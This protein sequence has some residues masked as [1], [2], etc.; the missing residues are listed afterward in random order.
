MVGM[1]ETVPVNVRAWAEAAQCRALPVG[2][3][4]ATG[5]SRAA[6]QRARRQ[7]SCR[8]AADYM[9]PIQSLKAS[10]G[11]EP[12]VHVAMMPP[13]PAAPRAVIDTNAVLDW[14]VFAEPAALTL[15]D[16][17]ARRR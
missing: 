11:A 17:I 3:G 15:G 6:R 1:A 13:G 7:Q 4:E 9:P 2:G 12:R 10:Q 5:P 14:L 8:K 16:A